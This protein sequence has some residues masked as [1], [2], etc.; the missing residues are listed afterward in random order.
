M[1]VLSRLDLSGPK[2]GRYVCYQTKWSKPMERLLAMRQAMS[3]TLQ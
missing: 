2:V 3:L 1:L